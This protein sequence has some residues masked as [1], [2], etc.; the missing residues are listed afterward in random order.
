MNKVLFIFYN[1]KNILPQEI[2]ILSNKVT[3]TP[4]SGFSHPRG[5]M[6][7][8]IIYQR[9]LLKPILPTKFAV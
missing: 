3:L 8:V 6:H 1:I 4:T 7:S 2:K 5:C 9:F